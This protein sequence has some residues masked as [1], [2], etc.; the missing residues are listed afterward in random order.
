MLLS[1]EEVTRALR[2]TATTFVSREALDLF[3]DGDQELA[4]RIRVLTFQKLAAA[5]PFPIKVEHL[6]TESHQDLPTNTLRIYGQWAPVG[7]LFY[8]RDVVRTGLISGFYGYGIGSIRPS[9][10]LQ[11]KFPVQSLVSFS[12]A[13]GLIEIEDVTLPLKGWDTE[14]NRWVYQ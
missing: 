5:L 6:V 12:S 10:T 1:P 2:V 14:Q 13:A 11:L 4:R 8:R 7:P 9:P 3:P